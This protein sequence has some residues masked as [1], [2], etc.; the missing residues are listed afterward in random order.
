[1][2]S[3]LSWSSGA[4]FTHTPVDTPTVG[5]RG[6]ARRAGSMVTSASIEPPRPG[7]RRRR[8]ARDATR[9]AQREQRLLIR[10]VRHRL[11][12]PVGVGVVE[13]VVAAVPPPT[14]SSQMVGLCAA[15]TSSSAIA[16]KQVTTS[17]DRRP[18]RARFAP[19]PARRRPSGAFAGSSL[20]RSPEQGP[21]SSPSSA[22]V[23]GRLA[24]RRPSRCTCPGPCSSRASGRSSN[25][26]T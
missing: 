4:V 16:S 9:V 5:R 22:A 8:G 3:Q 14:T 26:G 21:L 25:V 1:M 2:R 20:L 15:S 24:A 6:L 23:R 12:Q 17:P 18:C 7:R 13:R 10:E 11:E 19:R